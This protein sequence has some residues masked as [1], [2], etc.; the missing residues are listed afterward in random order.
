MIIDYLNSI[1]DLNG[2][3]QFKIFS[4]LINNSGLSN[5]L[6]MRDKKIILLVP[7]DLVF[8][9][10][11]KDKLDGIIELNK[12]KL[13]QLIQDHIIFRSENNILV[14]SNGDRYVYKDNKINNINIASSKVF[15]MGL[16]SIIPITNI[17]I[18]SIKTKQIKV[19]S[20]A[21]LGLLDLAKN[22]LFHLIQFLDPISLTN[23]CSTH[24]KF[25]SFCIRE[26]YNIWN[27][28]LNKDFGF[29]VRKD[30]KL[31]PKER[32]FRLYGG[33]LWSFGDNEFG[34]LG[35]V[36]QGNIDRNPTP[37]PVFENIIVTK[38]SCESYHTMVITQ[39][40]KLWSF[41]DNEFGQL[42]RVTQGNENPIPML[43]PIFKDMIIINVS[44]GSFHTMVITQGNKLWSFGN[45]RSGQLGRV[46]Q[47]NDN[48]TPR[49]VPA[50]EDMVV[51]K[52]SCGSKHTMVITEGGK[53]WSFG[54]NR[55][56]QL[57]KVT[58]V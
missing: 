39:D 2:Q 13:K 24:P 32:Y 42:G 6:N 15:K 30:D 37:V 11:N 9:K 17:I 21:E 19:I 12:E 23:F 43:V 50:F 53:L 55:Y 57:G 10:M 46:T 52:I 3:I 35:R 49:L 41:G 34:Q 38:V 54:Y 8:L 44:C 40:G 20:N 56:C 16:I 45:N 18:T 27:Y 1:N 51:T 33:K 22:P 58:Q 47:G 25:R 48:P 26:E 29:T 31:G 4:K 36:T 14:N 5:N 7:I 28:M